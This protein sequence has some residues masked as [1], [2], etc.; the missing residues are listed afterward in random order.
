MIIMK[1]IIPFLPLLLIV[2]S[3]APEIKLPELPEPTG[4]VV[5]AEHFTEDP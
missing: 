1:K 3:E 5:L 2:C 4:R